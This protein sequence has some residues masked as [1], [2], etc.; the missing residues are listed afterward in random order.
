MNIKKHI[1][2]MLFFTQALI[3]S[4][5]KNIR[6]VVKND[7]GEPVIGATVVYKGSSIGTITDFD[8]LFEL[9]VAKQEAP[10]LVISYV[11]F[12]TQEI[13]VAGQKKVNVLLVPSDIVLEEVIVTALGIK[14]E[15]KSLTY[16]SQT[17]DTDDFS[18]TRT[19]NFL[20]NLSGKVA[21][22]QI[23]SSGSP[24]G[25]NRVVIRGAT[26]LTE[27]NQPLY[28]IDGI[29]M[30]TPQGDTGLTS[31]DG[32]IDYGN[33]ISQINP[34]DIESIEVLKGA[35][36]TSLYGSQGANGVILITTKTGRNTN[37]IGISIN[38][39][40]MFTDILEYPN[41]QYVY[42]AGQIG[43]LALNAG[44]ID[45]ET[46]YPNSSRWDRAYGLPMLG[47]DVINVNKEPG[48]YFV[49][50]D[51]IKE[52]YS[53]GITSS[54]NISLQGSSEKGSYRLSYGFLDSEHTISGMNEQKR[55]NI[56]FNGNYK[57][58]NKVES[59][60]NVTFVNDLV[61]NRIPTNGNPRNP[62]SAYIFMKPNFSKD[63]LIPYKDELSGV[64]YTYEGPFTNP[65][66]NI[67]ENTNQDETNRV[68]FGTDLI[69]RPAKGYMFKLKATT[70]FR[71][72]VSEVLN[73]KGATYDLDGEYRTGDLT[74]VTNRYT[75][76][77]TVNKRVKKVSIV[78]T[79][80][81]SLFNTRFSNRTIRIDQLAESG[82][83]TVA[84]N[85]GYPVVGEVDS[86]KE[87]QSLFASAS[88]G[89]KS[90]YYLELTARNDWS[91]TLPKANNSYFYPS[92]GTTVVFSKFIPKNDIL[93]FG[94]LRGSY[95][96]V[97]NDTAPNRTL[98]LYEYGG[99]YLGNAYFQLP[100]TKL[101][102]NLVPERSKTIEFG[103]ETFFFKRRIKFDL[104][105]YQTR[106]EDQIMELL[107]SPGTGYTRQFVNAG[108]LKNS[109]FEIVLNA[110]IFDG[111]DKGFHW[112][113]NINWSNNQTYV[114]SL[115]EGL[116]RVELG[117]FFN[118]T[119]G[120]EVGEKFGQ[121]R[122]RA[123]AKDPVTGHT[124]V[125]NNGRALFENDVYLGNAQA[126][127]IGGLRNSFGYKD[128]T[129]S[130]LLDVKMGGDLLSG[131]SVKATNAGV[132]EKTLYA[133]E[134]SFFGE[135]VLGE[136]GNERRGNGLYGN[137]YADTVIKG[138]Y[139]VNSALGVRDAEGNLVAER[140][141]EG[142]VI[143]NR[144]YM[145]SQVY[146]YDDANNQ[147]GHVYDASYVR[148][149]EVNLGYTL[150]QNI[151]SGTGIQ[152]VKIAAVARNLW[153]LYKNTP[154][155]IDPEAQTNSGNGRGI[156]YGSPLPTFNYGLNVN[157]KF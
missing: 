18:E 34:D 57:L 43:R 15:K 67:Y 123:Y 10:V 130:F 145:N 139:H 136:N 127:W 109:G 3:Y 22:V 154:E 16:A 61:K 69:Y 27:D 107:T 44:H 71:S 36:A 97:G 83:A 118:A 59:R 23:T 73:N 95:G 1:V 105:W 98:N 119:V 41:Y 8:G 128:I 29:Q 116:E 101:N 13:P 153:F 68:L 115:P 24:V 126:D 121:I 103:T 51:N 77:F 87:I 84:N 132:Y 4:Q 108:V 85:A 31:N 76:L 114:E 140:D 86:E 42:G 147:I 117:R 9:Q 133:R 17:V 63:N 124:L 52:I 142:N 131:T 155:G 78:S 151:L 80:G 74:A 96:E 2:L 81:A 25:S 150:P 88:L 72:R 137:D 99:N 62:A 60:V 148:L 111:K 122:G 11:G 55:N 20:N 149:R 112:D 141:A 79:L 26:S 90:T 32:G 54:T 110:T 143:E 53:T 82:Y 5:N 7:K 64:A 144:R 46:G 129:F 134:D 113:A 35:G 30:S 152:S 49:Q 146:H 21:G 100:N 91:S 47:Q 106:T 75:G 58:T 38:Q 48:Q 19:S 14:R 50:P 135:V 104:T 28:V 65:Y 56:S 156:E 93:T 12:V 138:A 39:N 157:V 102:E 92:I 94:K 40:L 120:A 66:W 125:S 45:S 70:D 6:G 89:Y 37:G 33:P